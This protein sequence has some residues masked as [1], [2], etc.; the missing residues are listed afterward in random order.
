MHWCEDRLLIYYENSDNT[1]VESQGRAKHSTADE[2]LAAA[3]GMGAH[4]VVL[5]HFSQRYPRLPPCIVTAGPIAQ[6]YIVAFDGMEVPFAI[7][8]E[9]PKLMPLLSLALSAQEEIADDSAEL[10]S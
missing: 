1:I 3:A 4:R 7:L 9:L 6:R 5:T 8:G 2:A 10:N